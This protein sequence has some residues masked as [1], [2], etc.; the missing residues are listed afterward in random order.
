MFRIRLYRTIGQLLLIEYILKIKGVRCDAR[1][2]H[3]YIYRNRV[4]PVQSSRT[5]FCCFRAAKWLSLS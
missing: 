2:T 3:T 1:N 5:A 4:H